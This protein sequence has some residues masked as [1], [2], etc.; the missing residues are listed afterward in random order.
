[1]SET[2]YVKHANAGPLGLLGFGMTTLLLN[3][4][5]VGVFELSIVIIAM[6][7]MLGGLAQFIAGIMEFRAGN[8]FGATAFTS[9]G[10]FWWSLILIWL[11]PYEKLGIEAAD[12]LSLGFYFLLWCIY[13]FFMFIGTIKGN[14]ATRIVFG[15]LML[16]FLFLALENFAGSHTLGIVAGV[17]GI[18]SG[19]SAI[20]TAVASVV[21]EEFGKN[22]MPM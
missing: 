4:H 2:N 20:Y 9:Y 13:T 6:G 14:N 22:L 19:A 17:I 7:I 1:M 16:L 15:T 11:L 21:D 12:S 18:I 8:T 3:L 10:L 5:N